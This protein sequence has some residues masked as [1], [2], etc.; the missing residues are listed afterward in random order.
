[1]VSIGVGDENLSIFIASNQFY[2]LL[3]SLCIQ[4]VEDVIEQQQWG[5]LR[6]RTFQEVELSQLQGDYK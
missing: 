3:Y 1:V 4:F 5:S 2:Y 6:V